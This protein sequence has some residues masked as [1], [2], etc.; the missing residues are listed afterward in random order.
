MTLAAAREDVERILF[1]AAALAPRAEVLRR[2]LH[3]LSIEGDATHEPDAELL[4]RWTE[5]V[6]SLLLTFSI[7]PQ[8]WKD[9]ESQR[10]LT[11]CAEIFGVGRGQAP[12][13]IQRFHGLEEGDR[14]G[15][16]LYLSPF[17]PFRYLLHQFN[18]NRTP[19]DVTPPGAAV[20]RLTRLIGGS[21]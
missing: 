9:P 11:D 3:Q 13:L 19:R 18:Q 15:L 21:P 1:E 16:L 7:E 12:E 2:A 20:A 4:E 6:H 5:I 14:Y 8:S 10:L 17:A